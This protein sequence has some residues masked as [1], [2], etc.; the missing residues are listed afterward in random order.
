MKQELVT[1]VAGNRLDIDL[2]Y[3]PSVSVYLANVLVVRRFSDHRCFC[4]SIALS[5]L[6][7]SLDESV[8]SNKISAL[9]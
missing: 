1:C 4:H 6:M 5:L 7:L 8:L 3:Y 9:M 2:V